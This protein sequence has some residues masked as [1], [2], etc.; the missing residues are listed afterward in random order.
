MSL[1]NARMAIKI[2]LSGSLKISCSM[3]GLGVAVSGNTVLGQENALRLASM[4]LPAKAAAADPK[5]QQDPAQEKPSETS[6]SDVPQKT[7]NR[8][9]LVLPALTIPNT[10]IVGVGTGATPEDQVSGRLPATISL[11]H[12]SD[13]FGFWALENKTWLA[14]VFCHQPVY[15]EDTMLERHGHERLPCLQP[16]LSGTRFFSDIVFLPYN[17][18]LQRPLEERYNTGHYRQ[19]SAAPGLRQRAPYDAGAMRFQLLTT[20]TAVLAVQP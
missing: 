9:P 12:G 17:A 19:G 8:E 13:R 4:T 16:V 1:T 3:V 6:P 2:V 14:P 7:R 18:Y 20:G 5:P 15:F 10:S 11:P